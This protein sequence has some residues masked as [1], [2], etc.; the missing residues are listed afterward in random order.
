MAYEAWML[1]AMEEYGHMDTRT[2]RINKVA[3]F[4]V[5]QNLSYIGNE[6]FVQACYACN[7]DP[8]Y[9]D[10]EDMEKIERKIYELT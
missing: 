8:N 7:I 2:G 3:R 6:E 10:Q 9:F 5:Q 1:A 4:L